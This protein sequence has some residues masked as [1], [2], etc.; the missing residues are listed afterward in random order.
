MS[1]TTPSFSSYE[2]ESRFPDLSMTPSPLPPTPPPRAPKKLPISDPIPN[3]AVSRDKSE[4]NTA[5]PKPL[6]STV[7]ASPPKIR[8]L[9]SNGITALRPRTIKRNII[10][11]RPGPRCSHISPSINDSHQG[12]FARLISRP[13]SSF[14]NKTQSPI[15]ILMTQG[16]ATM[17]TT[18]S[19]GQAPRQM[20]NNPMVPTSR[21]WRQKSCH[22]LQNGYRLSIILPSGMFFLYVKSTLE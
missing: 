4:T 6:Y 1:F 9:L 5:N 10:G 14:L 22:N 3:T 8:P 18:P 20:T 12:E 19:M 7:V 15:P 21:D 17:Q 2:H 16:K 11:R 13:N